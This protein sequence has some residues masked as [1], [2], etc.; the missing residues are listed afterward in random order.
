[1]ARLSY[2]Q[3]DQAS[4][5]VREIYEKVLRVKPVSWRIGFRAGKP[6]GAQLRKRRT[7][8]R[9]VRITHPKA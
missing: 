6:N 4:P 9:A 7:S 2:V 5:K 1:M 3:M 8:R